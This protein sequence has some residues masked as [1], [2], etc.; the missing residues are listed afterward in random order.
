MRHRIVPIGHVISIFAPQLGIQHRHRPVG[1]DAVPLGIGGIVLQRAESERVFVEVLRLADQRRDEV[2]TA[3]VMREIAEKAAA[4]RIISQVLN[5]AATVG[6]GVR[7]L[8]LLRGCVGK[9]FEEQFLEGGIPHGIDDGFVGENRIA[10]RQ[11]ARE[12]GR[13]DQALDGKKPGQLAAPLIVTGQRYSTTVSAM[14]SP[15]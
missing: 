8:Q 1:R 4:E 13:K 14:A 11:R 5:D 9:S 6:V 15:G 3:D 12:H 2:P 10:V 7:L